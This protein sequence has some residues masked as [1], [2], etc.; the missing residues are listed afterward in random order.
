MVEFVKYTGEYP[1][2]CHGELTVKI[3]GEEVTFASGCLIS[4]GD[5]WFDENWLEH[6]EAGAWKVSLPDEY[7]KYT[8]EVEKVVN[9]NVPWG[10]CGGC[11]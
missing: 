4:G 9:E 3:D 8:E 1:C 11:V 7:A 2:A 10:C 5:V 6:V